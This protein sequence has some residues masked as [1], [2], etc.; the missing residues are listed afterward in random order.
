MDDSS[1]HFSHALVNELTDEF[2][3]LNGRIIDGYGG[4]W[5]VWKTTDLYAW[6]HAFEATCQTP[7]GRKLMNACADQEEF[8][9]R[10]SGLLSGGR[11]LKKR[12][13]NAFIDARWKRYG[14]GVIESKHQTSNSLVFAP[15]ISGFALAT[16]E[17]I[18]AQR[19][20]LEWRQ[21]GQRLIQFDWTED[22]S[23]LPPAPEPPSLP[24]GST[25]KL[26]LD[27]VQVFSDFTWANEGWSISGESVC[28]L[29]MD[30]FSRLFHTCRAFQHSLTTEQVEAW[31]TPDFTSGDRT[32][33]LMISASMTQLVNGSEQPIYIENTASWAS[34]TSHYLKPFGWGV[35]ISIESLDTEHGVRFELEDSP[36]L[37]F[38]TGWLVAMWERAH[39]RTVKFNLTKQTE[40]WVLEVDS[41]LNY[42][43]D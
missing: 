43:E 2:H 16:K 9:L 10:R 5:I 39:G 42:I 19:Y 22:A 7:L 11:F 17:Q 31:S 30:A 8:L 3:M 28:L 27:Q 26:G 29:P 20:K 14:W 13:Q 23:T 21:T 38:L 40:T 4:S 18:N 34:L 6:W 15:I 25:A 24:W 41:R 33:F 12:R 35:P 1:S 36:V 37:P 32:V